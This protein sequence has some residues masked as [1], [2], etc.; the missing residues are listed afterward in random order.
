MTNVE[1]LVSVIN[2]WKQGSTY[3]NA[4]LQVRSYVIT[5][6]NNWYQQFQRKTSNGIFV[7]LEIQQS[8]SRA[9]GTAI[10]GKSDID[11]FL[12]FYDPHGF[13][14][15]KE[16][17]ND[18]YK[19]LANYFKDIRKQNVSIGL[20][21]NGC[22]I[23]IVPARKVNSSSY[24][25]L[26][27]RYNDHYLWSNKR[28]NRMLTNIQKHIDLVRYSGLLDEMILLKVWR[29][30]HKLEFP[31]IYMEL[32]TIDAFSGYNAS[33]GTI[34]NHFLYLLRYVRDNIESKRVVDPS[35]SSNIL[36][37]DLT[38]AEKRAIKKAAQEAIDAQYWSYVVK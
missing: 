38:L 20:K 27:T 29:E 14:T 17:Y 16:I 9:K 36:S 7:S 30:Q 1:Y 21:F 33:G 10:K 37:D 6:I 31:S 8:G 35:N 11:L 3:S 18:I 24:E 2:K 25:K 26:R 13:F 4:E 5:L 34:E 12:S 32:F 28:Q 23:D 19:F 22:D 15:L